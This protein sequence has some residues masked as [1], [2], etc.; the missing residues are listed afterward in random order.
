VEVCTLCTEGQCVHSSVDSM[1]AGRYGPSL[2]S[3]AVLCGALCVQ[4]SG[5]GGGTLTKPVLS[6]NSTVYIYAKEMFEAHC[7][8]QGHYQIKPLPAHCTVHS[9]DVVLWEEA[10]VCRYVCFFSSVM[11]YFVTLFFL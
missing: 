9:P 3:T 2:T 10:F 1:G 4:Y 6:V 7:S 5:G 11:D 8:Y